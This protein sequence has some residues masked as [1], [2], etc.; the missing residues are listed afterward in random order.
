MLIC[1]HSYDDFVSCVTKSGEMS[2]SRFPFFRKDTMSVRSW[3]RLAAG[4]LLAAGLAQA[5]EW[6]VQ[7]GPDLRWFDWRESLGG[8]QLLMERGPLPSLSLQ[9]ELRAG[10]VFARADTLLG[11]GLAR[12]DGHLQSGAAY[13]ANAWE[14]TSD[15]HLRLGWRG[16]GVEATGGYLQRDWLRHIDGS[17]TVSSAEER[18]RWRIITAGVV[19]E[20][21]PGWRLAVEFGYP[22]DSYQKVYSRYYDDFTLEPGDGSYWRLALLHRLGRDPR[23]TVEPWFQS[24]SMADS[25]P[26]ALTLNGVP[27]G[28]RA[29]QPASV[30][31][32]LGVT[33]R[34]QLG[35]SREEAAASAP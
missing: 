28:V 16:L 21:T 34:F 4:L 11:G 9:V 6:R 20:V 27:A 32:E 19:G 25:E 10:G 12:Y 3:R 14:Q 29:Y 13:Q 5:E 30:R 26:V 2:A 31:R 15:T 33:L 17:A 7:V 23:L 1:W 22:V 18:Y 24:Q 35:V 8:N